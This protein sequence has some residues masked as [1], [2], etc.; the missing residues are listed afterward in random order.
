MR[1]H[2][3]TLVLGSA[4]LPPLV[5]AAW[6]ASRAGYL[7]FAH[8]RP[9]ERAQFVSEAMWLATFTTATLATVTLPILVS[10]IVTEKHYRARAMIISA[11]V[12]ATMLAATAFSLESRLF[13]DLTN[14]H[15]GGGLVVEVFARETSWRLTVIPCI[16]AAADLWVA[17]NMPA[18]KPSKAFW[19]LALL[20][21]ALSV[22][23]CQ[24]AL[25]FAQSARD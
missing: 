20:A 21:Y 15:G 1:C 13:A 4:I 3:R 9:D 2:L 24:H 14:W 25:R 16:L 18:G 19:V 11:M 8:S 12:A 5:A 6:W 17:A 10:S 23:L 22:V 7:I